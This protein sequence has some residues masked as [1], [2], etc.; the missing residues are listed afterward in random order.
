MCDQTNYSEV[1]LCKEYADFVSDTGFLT[2]CD[3]GW[4]HGPE[5]VV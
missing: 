5:S 3:S 2:H 4:I 1:K